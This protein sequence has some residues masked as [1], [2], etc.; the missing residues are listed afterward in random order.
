MAA[1]LRPT[2]RAP[3]T[4]H[5]GPGTF[6]LPDPIELTAADSNVVWSGAG[7]GITTIRGGMQ[8]RN[9]VQHRLPHLPATPVWRAPNPFGNG[10]GSAFYHLVEGEVR[11]AET[12]RAAVLSWHFHL[13]RFLGES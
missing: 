5:L 7:T 12:A 6:Y 1:A 13:Q 10:T 9:W 8:I 4:V 2:A 3:V 11:G